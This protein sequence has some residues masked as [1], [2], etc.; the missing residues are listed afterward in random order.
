VALLCAALLTSCGKDAPPPPKPR[1]APPGVLIT[2][3]QVQPRR[4]EVL[5]EVVGSLE[6]MMD[7]KLGAEVAG[8]V[9]R[10]RTARPSRMRSEV[11]SGSSTYPRES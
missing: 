1:A 11:I 9:I 3:T 4:F 10:V 5:E 6:N 7:P 2:A 8:K